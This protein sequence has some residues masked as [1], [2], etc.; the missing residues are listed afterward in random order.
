MVIVV[1]SRKPENYDFHVQ[2]F[3]QPD[4]N[5]IECFCTDNETMFPKKLIFNNIN[6]DK[7]FF[8]KIIIKT[9]I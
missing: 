1:R 9:D 5:K 4:M 7:I 8:R 3:L 6:Y 2:E